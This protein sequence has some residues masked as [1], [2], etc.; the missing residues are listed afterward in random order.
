M[1]LDSVLSEI[2]RVAGTA[3]EVNAVLAD[4]QS[5]RKKLA[6]V[7]G[8]GPA[9]VVSKANQNIGIGISATPILV[10][11]GILLYAVSTRRR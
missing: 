8:T 1:N 6:I 9:F 3:Q 5:G 11:F 10:A 7:P 2:Q 4:L